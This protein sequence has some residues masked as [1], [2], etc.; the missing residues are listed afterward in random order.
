[1]S[2][3]SLHISVAA[4]AK[5]DGDFPLILENDL[6]LVKASLLYADK[7]KL[8]SITGWLATRFYKLGT[9]PTTDVEQLETIIE[10]STK[11]ME[12][13]ANIANILPLLHKYLKLFKR[14]PITLTKRERL[15]KV[16]FKSKFPTIWA[17]IREQFAEIPRRAGYSEMEIAAQRNLL[18]FHPFP[19]SDDELMQE[20][21]LVVKEMLDSPS[22]HPLFDEQTANL[23][24]LGVKAGQLSVK[25][26]R[27]QSSK[28]VGLVADLFDRL[29]VYDIPMAALLDLRDELHNPLTR[30][31]AEMIKL[32]KDIESA[33]WDEDF[34]FDVQNVVQAHVEP[35][36]LEIE[37]QLKSNSFKEFWSRRVVDKYGFLAGT[38]GVLGAAI[39]PLAGIGAAML[40]TALFI[41]AGQADLRDK[42]DATERNGLYFYYKVKKRV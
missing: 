22:T 25:F 40:G 18:E 30:F 36:L 32:S 41:K 34:P 37:E 38:A 26:R 24:Q 1:M 12:M 15:E 2:T 4:V 3:N 19:A 14:S 28:Q 27:V 35:A 6:R 17:P 31:R 16:E 10:L 39:S 21:W 33:P 11:F 20:Y 13:D 5:P 7:V 42:I 23:V 29:P 8:C 9:K